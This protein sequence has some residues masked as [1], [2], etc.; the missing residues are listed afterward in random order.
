MM[1]TNRHHL[2]RFQPRSVSRTTF[3]SLKFRAGVL[4]TSYVSYLGYHTYKEIVE[5]CELALHLSRAPRGI[6]CPPPVHW[7]LPYYYWSRITG[8]MQDIYLSSAMDIATAENIRQWN[9]LF[10]DIQGLHEKVEEKFLRI[11]R[12]NINNYTMV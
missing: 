10:A 1:T 5:Y 11:E 9:R 4:R 6:I 7:P 2:L 8:G 3:G 12:E